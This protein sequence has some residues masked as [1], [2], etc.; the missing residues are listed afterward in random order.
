MEKILVVGYGIAGLCIARQLEKRQVDYHVIDN[1]FKN[2]SSKVA[3]GMWNPIG[4]KRLTKSWKVDELLPYAQSFYSEFD[5]AL[6][7]K[8]TYRHDLI[9]FFSS[10]EEENTWHEKLDDPRFKTYISSEKNAHIENLKPHLNPPYNYGKVH[11]AGRVDIPNLLS[12]SKDRLIEK[13]S[14]SQG[15]FNY[16][17]LICQDGFWLYGGNQYTGVIFCEGHQVLKNPYFKYLPIRPNKGEVFVLRIPGLDLN[18]VINRGFFILPLGNDLFKIGATF[19]S[20]D[21]SYEP[22]Q[23]GLNWLKQK[24]E[25]L[26]NLP[27]ELVAHQ[28]GI[29]PT[30]P[31]RKPMAGRHSEHLNLFLFNGLGAKGI[32]LAPK[33]S[34]YLIRYIFD[35][36]VLPSEIDISRY[37]KWDSPN[38]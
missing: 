5:E 34:E 24:M 13:G 36:E 30:T 11:H 29:R 37:E 18:C 15:L 35:K 3:A 14:I 27:Y 26:V 28:S 23:S 12:L 10:I 38:L 31:D 22:T 6:S 19:N 25:S 17:D 2:A 4:F 33:L 21:H 8:I 20:R 32:Y 16:S 9:R 7:E 1:G